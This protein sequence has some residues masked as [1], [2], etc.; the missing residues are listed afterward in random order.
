VARLTAEDVAQLVAWFETVELPAPPFRSA[1]WAIIHKPEEWRAVM[2]RP[3]RHGIADPYW[4]TSLIELRWLAKR[5]APPDVQA[6]THTD[7][8]VEWRGPAF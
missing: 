8:L 6:A 7:E 2:L 4:Q 5:I 3:P 1:P